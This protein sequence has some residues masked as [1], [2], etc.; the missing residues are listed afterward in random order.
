MAEAE[1]NEDA[2]VL[3]ATLVPE[4]EHKSTAQRQLTYSAVSTMAV[5]VVFLLLAMTLGET[6]VSM[7]S[8]NEFEGEWWN[9]P[10]HLRHQMDL[11][12]DTL[13]AQLDQR[14]NE[15]LPGVDLAT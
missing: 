14:Y 13:R 4:M 15:V 6:L 9:T 8:E 3:A 11:P 10:L 7:N 12:M 5:A 2:S 1:G